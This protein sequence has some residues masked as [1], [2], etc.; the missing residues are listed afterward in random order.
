MTLPATPMT[1]GG[2][3]NPHLTSRDIALA[4]GVSQATVSNVLNR[5]EVVA[6]KTLNRVKAVM[7]SMNF[8]VNDSARSLRAGKSKTLG[9]IA[10]DLSNPFWGEVTRGIE[11]IATARGYS[12]LIGSS[13]ERVDKELMLLRLFEENRVDGILVS[14]L[15]TSSQALTALR[16][17]GV[18]VVFLDGTD[19]SGAHSSVSFDQVAGAHLVGAHLVERGHKRIAFLNVPHTVSWSRN[20]LKGLREG[21]QVAGADPDEVIT[22]IMIESMTALAAEPA[23]AQLQALYPD[24]T[25]VFCANDLVALGVLKQLSE[26]G[27]VVPRDLSVVGFDDS[28]FS[29]LLSPALTSVRQEPFLLGQKAAQV[30]I[31]QDLNS[32][33]EPIVFQ[34]KLIVRESVRR[35]R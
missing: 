4:A 27:K 9:V 24:V 14:S 8:V 7:A 5:P 3:E 31:D 2:P 28:Y 21:I 10:L 1:P 18:K 15:N 33:P 22:E 35:I 32:V 17:R 26:R 6:T 13:E 16:D 11:A 30:I 25:A 20:R 12:I 19:P 34:P 23:V 29:S